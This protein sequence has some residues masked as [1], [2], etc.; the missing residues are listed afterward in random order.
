MVT[1]K[2]SVGI[3]GRACVEVT[4]EVSVSVGQVVMMIRE[5]LVMGYKGGG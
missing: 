1:W 3:T 2:V 4:G 5:G